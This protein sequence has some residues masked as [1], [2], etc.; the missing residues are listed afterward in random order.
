MREENPGVVGIL[1]CKTRCEMKSCDVDEKNP[2]IDIVDEMHN[3]GIQI[4]NTKWKSD[5]MFLE[6]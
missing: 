4:M 2:Y 5:G 6:A 3:D 1:R